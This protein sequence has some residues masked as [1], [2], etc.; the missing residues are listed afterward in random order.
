MAHKTQLT[1][2]KLKAKIIGVAPTIDP[3]KKLSLF[4][5]PFIVNAVFHDA[6]LVLCFLVV[7][8]R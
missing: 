1:H 2:D 5:V 7:T 4:E 3:T 6:S 8:R